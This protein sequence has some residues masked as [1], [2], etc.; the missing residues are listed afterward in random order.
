[1]GPW[2]QPRVIDYEDGGILS[3]IES[4]PLTL[5]PGEPLYAE[6]HDG[7]VHDL[8]GGAACA[9]QDDLVE[10]LLGGLVNDEFLSG[11]G[12]W[13]PSGKAK[14]ARRL[15]TRWWDWEWWWYHQRED[16]AP[17][18]LE[19]GAKL[20]ESLYGRDGGGYDGMELFE[21]DGL[22]AY[23]VLKERVGGEERLGRIWREVGIIQELID[24]SRPSQNTLV[25]LSCRPS[26]SPH[27]SSH[28]SAAT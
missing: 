14:A 25:T 16:A 12:G 22:A 20:S 26:S 2:D 10:P 6:F 17:P 13:D 7:Q 21:M 24:K 28:R 4:L 3:A 15:R 27:L 11:D 19:S 5:A 23:G 1:M 9:F 18:G 8:L